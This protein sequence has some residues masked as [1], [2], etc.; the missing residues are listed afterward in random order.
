[1]STVFERFFELRNR[2][3]DEVDLERFIP[4][5]NEDETLD[6]HSKEKPGR[7]IRVFPSGQ[8]VVLALMKEGTDDWIGTAFW[9]EEDLPRLLEDAM[10]RVTWD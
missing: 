3:A 9:K 5:I 8:M 7:W 6:L 2:I 4:V 1:M 10:M